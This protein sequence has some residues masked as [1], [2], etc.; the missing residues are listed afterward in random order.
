MSKG[1]LQ[2]FLQDVAANPALR[3]AF[4]QNPN[5][6]IAG[7]EI[8]PDE[9]GALKSRDPERIKKLGIDERLSAA[10]T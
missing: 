9:M 5:A 7:Y 8:A 10:L 6:A 3:T 4:D 2:R 1:E